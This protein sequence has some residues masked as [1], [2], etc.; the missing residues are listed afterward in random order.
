[1]TAML[2]TYDGA[3][4]YYAEHLRDLVAKAIQLGLAANPNDLAALYPGKSQLLDA[5]LDEMFPVEISWLELELEGDP[6]VVL[7]DGDEDED[8]VFFLLR[9]FVGFLNW[10]RRLIAPFQR[11]PKKIAD[12]VNGMPEGKIK[13][14]VLELLGRYTPIEALGVVASLLL[15][16]I[17]S[18]VEG[19][20]ENVEPEKPVSSRVVRQPKGGEKPPQKPAAPAKPAAAPAKPAAAPAKPASRVERNKKR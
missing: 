3:R 16:L 2:E 11:W 13:D 18:D 1:M 5:V 20:E 6:E 19:V 9:P 10:L 14:G 15:M 7:T 4:E 17:V 8:E 12:R